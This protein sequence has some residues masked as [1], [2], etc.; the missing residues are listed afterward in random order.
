MIAQRPSAKTSFSVRVSGTRPEYPRPTT[1]CPLDVT[2]AG[3]R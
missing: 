1:A 2:A 3:S